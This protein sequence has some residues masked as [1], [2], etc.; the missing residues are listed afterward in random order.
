[1]VRSSL[2]LVAPVPTHACARH[3]LV[4]PA[5]C[6]KLEIQTLA[7]QVSDRGLVWNTDLVETLELENLLINA[8]ITMHSAEQRKVRVLKSL[9]CRLCH[10]RLQL[11]NCVA[12]TVLAVSLLCP[13]TS[14]DSVHG[15]WWSW[16]GVHAACLAEVATACPPQ[17]AEPAPCMLP[18]QESRGAH[19]REDFSARDDKNWMKHTLGYFDFEKKGSKVGLHFGFCLFLGCFAWSCVCERNGLLS[20]LDVGN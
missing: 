13:L 20:G 5:A 1:M 12:L 11:V 4:Q 15:G 2:C 19:A 8:A 10:L 9:P 6:A 18:P 16:G 7:A 14:K 3:N 17:H